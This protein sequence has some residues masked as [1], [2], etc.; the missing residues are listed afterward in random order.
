M[1]CLIGCSVQK[2]DTYWSHIQFQDRR[3][4]GSPSHPPIWA[5]LLIPFYCWGNWPSVKRSD[6]VKVT[7]LES[8]HYICKALR[9][10]CIPLKEDSTVRR[11]TLQWASDTRVTWSQV[12]RSHLTV[13]WQISVFLQLPWASH[14]VSW[15]LSFLTFKMKQLHQM[16]SRLGNSL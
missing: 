3:L 5:L 10:V 6:W 7:Q 12:T 1:D 2:K 4:Y 11:G 13:T 8:D 9:I 15:G 14:L 16:P